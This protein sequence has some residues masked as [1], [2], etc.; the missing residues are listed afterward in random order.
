MDPADLRA[1]AVVM[2][3]RMPPDCQRCPLC[4]IYHQKSKISAIFTWEENCFY[5]LN[6]IYISILLKFSTFPESESHQ[7]HD[8][9]R[10]LNKI[11]LLLSSNL[12]SLNLILNVSP[13]APLVSGWH[14]F[15]HNRHN[16]TLELVCSVTANPPAKVKCELDL[17]LGLDNVFPG[18]L[19]SPNWE[20]RTQWHGQ[21]QGEYFIYSQLLYPPWL[22]FPKVV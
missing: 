18:G 14:S 16:I 15:T 21:I 11:S 12:L 10:S 9:S 13:D 8:A 2:E 17:G 4:I 19:E 3:V 22:K 5:K 6:T 7:H 1:I 20:G